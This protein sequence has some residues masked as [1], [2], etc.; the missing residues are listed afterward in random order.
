[1]D[2]NGEPKGYIKNEGDSKMS[3]YING[4]DVDSNIVELWS[5]KRLPFEPKGWLHDMRSSLIEAISQLEIGDDAFLRATYHS[6]V[7]ELC[8]LENIL[9]YN[10]GTGKF[11]KLCQQ[12]FLLERSFQSGPYPPDGFKNKLHYQRY[13]ITSQQQ[14]PVYWDTEKV[15][16]SWENI[17]LVKLTSDTKPHE[18]WKAMKEND[19]T[20][21]T[22]E[23]YGGYFGIDVQLTIPER[24]GFNLAVVVKTM[25]DGIIAA[26]HVHRGDQ[27]ELISERLARILSAETHSVAKLLL[28]GSCAV[29]GDRDLLYPFQNNVQWNPADDKCVAIKITCQKD[30]EKALPTISGFL[31]A[32]AERR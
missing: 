12:G 8:D 3:Y 17:S 28:D 18:Y 15:L 21:L 11:K 1:M 20:I 5:S 31:Y 10:V 9:L 23:A 14:R 32:A 25:L 29:L 27:T 7:L 6:E 26:F 2:V 19:V 30:T 24:K 4:P 13:E 22:N 16:A